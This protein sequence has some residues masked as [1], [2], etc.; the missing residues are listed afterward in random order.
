LIVLLRTVAVVWGAFLLLA[1]VRAGR[2]AAG[3]FFLLAGLVVGLLTTASVS[4]LLAFAVGLLIFAG[5]MAAYVYV[6]RLGTALAMV[7][8]FPAVF[9]AYLYF[10]GSFDR[11]L[12]LAIGLLVAGVLLGALLPRIALAVLS[13]ALATVLLFSGLPLDAGFASVIAVAVAGVLWQVLV[14]PRLWALKPSTGESERKPS[15]SQLWLGSLKWGSAVLAAGAVVVA[16]TVPRY[17]TTTVPEPD[18]LTELAA[19]RGLDRPGLVFSSYNNFYLS[20]RPLPVALVSAGSGLWS[21]LTLFPIGRSPMR[22]IGSM[23]AVKSEDELASMRRAA[24]ITS[25]AFEEIRPLIRPGVNEAEIAQRILD[26]FRDHGATGVAFESV[27]GSGANA[28]LPHYSKNDQVMREGLVVIDIGC[29]VDSYASDMTRTFPVSGEFTQEQRELVDIV[30]AAGDAA[31]ERLRAGAPMSD[32]DEAARDVIDEAGFGSYFTHRVGHHVG[33]NVHDP[34]NDPLA[35][36]MVVTIE[37][38]IYVPAG[39]DVDPA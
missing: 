37:P 35:A 24:T 18:R 25:K 7:W 33:L 10:S 26:A 14:L 30:I 22:A 17:D 21:R 12:P 5:G 1:G 39:A 20:G 11:N 29:S 38:G 32:V 16:I 13:S 8:P 2:G 6:P 31:R 36:G 27:V 3:T 19:E 23:R 15:R 28:V 34:G 9:A 4:Y